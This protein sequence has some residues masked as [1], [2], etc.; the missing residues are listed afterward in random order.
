MGTIAI[1]LTRLFTAL[2]KSTGT[3]RLWQ[4][5]EPTF[6]SHM[7]GHFKSIPHTIHYLTST[8][9]SLKK[10]AN[11][12]PSWKSIL[13]VLQYVLILVENPLSGQTVSQLSWLS[14]LEWE[15][16]C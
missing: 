13:Q 2:T 16:E 12:M 11:G 15:L 7:L 14:R 4:Q 1:Y 10:K 5:K 3:V 6:I 8:F 9:E